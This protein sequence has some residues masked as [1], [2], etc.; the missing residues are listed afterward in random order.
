[1]NRIKKEKKIGK[2]KDYN[3]AMKKNHQN[4][5]Y[6]KKII[7]KNINK[8]LRQNN[9]NNNSIGHKNNVDICRISNKLEKSINLIDK[10]RVNLIKY[11]LNND[12]S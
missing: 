2:N 8:N 10:L 6:I 9:K 4:Y 11:S 1:M 7:P 5:K 12:Y 3:Y